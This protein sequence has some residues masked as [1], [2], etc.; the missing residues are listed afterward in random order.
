MAQDK[1]EFAILQD[2]NGI[3]DRIVT[4]Y[5]EL[6]HHIDVKQIRCF[7]ITNKDRKPEKRPYDV[8]GVPLPIRLDCPYSWYVIVYG[9][10]W[11]E[12]TEKQKNLI[13]LLSLMHVGDEPGEVVKPD[14]Q[15]FACIL[16][17][18]GRKP[19]EKDDI[20]DVLKDHVDFVKSD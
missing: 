1:P 10:E 7:S 15:E 6:F 14:T 17:H 12:Y 20:K 11:A 8:Q 5:P 3:A 2:Y 18:M 4:K 13:I 19:W 9:R 16:D